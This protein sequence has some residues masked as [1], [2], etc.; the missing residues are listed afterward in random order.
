M[1][2]TVNEPSTQAKQN[3]TLHPMHLTA[4]LS[5]KRNKLLKEKAI[6]A[7]EEGNIWEHSKAILAQNIDDE[8]N[9]KQSRRACNEIS[10]QYGF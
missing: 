3:D 2:T 9:L 6:F 8:E 10:K 1:D 4:E 5:K 7:K